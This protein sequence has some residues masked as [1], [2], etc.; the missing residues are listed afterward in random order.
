M[1]KTKTVQLSL[2]GTVLS[3]F[4]ASASADSITMAFEQKLDL[5]TGIVSDA[6]IVPDEPNRADV[7][8]SYNADRVEH[9]VVFPANDVVEMAFVT[10]VLC[11]NV[12]PADVA[13]LTF[14][15]EPIDQPLS[16]NNCVVV[17]TDEGVLFKL[18]GATE[19]GMNVTFD[20]VAL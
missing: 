8:I 14:T 18:G 13:G 19:S 11:I 15:S 1:R 10:D 12:I 7:V 16:T 5:D 6:Y 4:A 9:V 3:L 20:S 2:I 17:R